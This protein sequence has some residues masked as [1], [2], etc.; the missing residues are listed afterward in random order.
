MNIELSIVNGGS[1][2]YP[3]VKDGITW[4]TERKGTPGVLKFTVI[5]TDDLYF[6]E[7]DAVRLIVDGTK[8]FFGFVFKKKR[9]K[10]HHIEVTAY[11][12][13]RYLKNKETYVYKNKTASDVIRMVAEDFMMNLGTLADTGYVIPQMVEDNKSLFDIVLNAMDETL[14]N[15]KRLYVLYDDFGHLTLNDIESM[16]T[17]VLINADTG[18]NFTYESSIDDQ[19]YN[20]IKVVYENE[21]TG[22]RD[23]YMAK[24]SAH[25]NDW[26]VL[27]YYEK[28]SS[29]KGLIEKVNKL[30]ELYDKKTRK[31]KIEKA[32]GSLN[33]RAGNSVV[34]M[35]DLGDITVHNM[36]V[37]EKVTHNF[38]N[39]YHTMDLTVIGNKEFIA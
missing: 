21:N 16:Q 31:L 4:E 1:I 36:M 13:L 6:S 22:K 27:Q 18:E 7:G 28:A 15:T 33:V 2:Y 26:G 38:Y 25:I 12:Q 8:V 3:C 37:C 5:K 20:Q 30:L 32:M 34:V 39:D 17:N 35:L 14:L 11:D 24:N 29:D 10:E 23:V 19:T 9:N